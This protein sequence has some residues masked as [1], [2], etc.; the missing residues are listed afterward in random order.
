MR[1]AAI[2]CVWL[3]LVGVSCLLAC[4]LLVSGCETVRSRGPSSTPSPPES[5]ASTP[6]YNLSGYSPAFKQ[7]YS[8]A[9]ATPRRRNGER[10]K[11]DTDYSMGWND[12]QSVCRGR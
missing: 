1:A 8:D 6:G 12:G 3:K 4:G 2:R 10:L 5:R 11:S 7:G 9:C